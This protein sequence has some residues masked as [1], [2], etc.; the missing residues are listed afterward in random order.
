MAKRR[1]ATTK[2]KGRARSRPLPGMEDRQI[3]D[4]EQVAIDYADIRDRRQALT[5]DEVDL[6]SRALNLMHKY[7]KTH[8]KRDGVEITLVP[9]EEDV[10][11][12]VK[13]EAD[14]HDDDESDVAPTPPS[15]GSVQ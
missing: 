15:S 14:A 13:K 8:Y 12:R 9:G 7:G 6:K 1:V 4:L 5:K 3:G 11:V 10:K 2:P